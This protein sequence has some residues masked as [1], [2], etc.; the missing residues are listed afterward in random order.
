MVTILKAAGPV[1]A[2][3]GTR[4]YARR[5]AE[6]D[7]DDFP[8]VYLYMTREEVDTITL[9]P[10][11]RRRQ[12]TMDISVDYWMKDAPGG[13]MMDDLDDAADKIDAALNADTTVGST[14]AD[15]VL[16]SVDHMYDDKEEAP[17][18]CVRLSYSLKYFTNES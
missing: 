16:T 14:A 13:N 1:A 9:S 17:H 10:T 15:I 4:V 6:L 5:Y 18:G 8:L 7:A 2:L 3:V 12:H 11:T